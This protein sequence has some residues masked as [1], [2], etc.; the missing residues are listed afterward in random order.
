MDRND[1][2]HALYYSPDATYVV[3]L[4]PQDAIY[5]VQT[6]TIR[7]IGKSD[8]KTLSGSVVSNLRSI[9]FVG[10]PGIALWHEDNG[11]TLVL[12]SLK[13]QSMSTTPV[14]EGVIRIECHTSPSH[15]TFL[16]S[17]DTLHSSWAEI[18]KIEGEHQILSKIH[19]VPSKPYSPTSWSA[20]VASNGEI[21][22]TWN[23]RS[24]ASEI[25]SGSSNKPVYEFAGNS[26]E[27]QA[28]FLS[29]SEVIP[30]PDRTFA[31]RTFLTS[32]PDTNTHLI[33]NGAVS[34]K[35]PESLAGLKAAI[36]VELL[37]PT[38][39]EVEG[40]LHVEESQNV[41]AAYIHRV[42]RH[43]HELM[44]YGPAWAA[45]LPTRIIAEF[46]GAKTETVAEGKFRDAFGFRK[47]IVGITS[48]GG[49][50]G[51]DFSQ[52]GK[53][54][55][56]LFNLFTP[57][58]IKGFYEIGKGVVG[59]VTAQGRYVEVDVFEGKITRKESPPDVTVMSTSLV[60][61]VG[62]KKVI[63]A[64]VKSSSTGEITVKYYGGEINT[65][66]ANDV[67]LTIPDSFG[68]V[69]G[70]MVESKVH[71]RNPHLRYDTNQLTHS[72][73]LHRQKNLLLLPPRT[74]TNHLHAPTH[75]PHPN[76]LHRPRHGRPL[77]HVQIPQPKPPPRH[78]PTHRQR[79]HRLSVPPRLRLRRS[80]LLRNPSSRG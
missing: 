42:K 36:W 6:T 34:W 61:G 58:D 14:P 73:D 27:I 25:Y 8:T 39:E 48:N 75:P 4:L 30:R 35:R 33:L 70:Y 40:E 28:A 53:V 52:R 57:V 38:T 80:P 5:R 76:R 21:Y 59:V 15:D 2:P 71:T 46:T 43:V 24:G 41:L 13:G 51:I 64:V 1:I 55:W 56:S 9:I 20:S 7:G 31:L 17:F 26:T 45:N 3:S 60:S 12:L 47:L 37:D 49:I 65:S 63:M 68:D 62:D 79:R 32:Y 69:H 29:V 44:V 22:F 16:I 19:D 74:R 66:A 77:R 23:L 18:W 78:H 50:V 72:P 11:R 54:L 67:Y 10:G